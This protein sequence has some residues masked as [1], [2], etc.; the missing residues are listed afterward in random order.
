VFNDAEAKRG[1]ILCNS[2]ELTICISP[3]Q[4]YLLYQ[5]ETVGRLYSL[6]VYT[7]SLSPSMENLVAMSLRAGTMW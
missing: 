5:M 3:L 7:L 1:C 4:R 2:Y 6:G